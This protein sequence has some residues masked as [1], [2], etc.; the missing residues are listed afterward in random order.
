MGFSAKLALL[1]AGLGVLAW[2]TTLIA[3]GVTT[4]EIQTSTTAPIAGDAVKV[5]VVED[6]GDRIVIDYE[7]GDFTKT[8][9]EIGQDTYAQIGLGEEGLMKEVVG[10]PELPHVCRSIVIPNDAE[11][12]ARVL[13]SDYYEI[14]DVR[15]PPS[16]GFISRKVNPNDVPYTFGEVYDVNTFYPQEVVT[17][18]EPY[19]LRDYRGVVV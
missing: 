6:T 7:I 1:G 5:H 16:K 8:P 13:A 19:I 11:M 12:E 9:V 18:R 15:V 14:G 2:S 3:A 17:L 4:E 10:A